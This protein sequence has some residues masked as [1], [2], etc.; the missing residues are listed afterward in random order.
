MKRSPRPKSTSMG[1]K[2]QRE[3]TFYLL[4]FQWIFEGVVDDIFGWNNFP[5]G[6]YVGQL[7]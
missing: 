4:P 6:N 3:E 7:N 1:T 5:R 2:C